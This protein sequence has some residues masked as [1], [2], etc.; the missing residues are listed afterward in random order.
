MKIEDGPAAVT[1]DESCLTSLS[2]SGDNWNVTGRR[3]RRMI[4]KS[5]DLPEKSACS[6]LNLLSRYRRG[7]SVTVCDLVDRKGHPRV[8]NLDGFVL[9]RNHQ[10]FGSG[11]FSASTFIF[12]TGGSDDSTRTGDGQDDALLD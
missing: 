11:F 9:L 5:E 2:Y 12:F 1:G 7:L 8:D 10:L 6:F 4:R 3:M